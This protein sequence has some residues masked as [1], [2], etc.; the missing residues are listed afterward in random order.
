VTGISGQY[1]FV[2]KQDQ[3]AK[4][5]TVK[6]ARTIGDDAVIETGLQPGEQVV[7]DGQLQLED[8]TRLEINSGETKSA[9]P[10]ESTPANTGITP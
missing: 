7:T 5:R 3:T 6:V 1:V 10:I 8:G 2:V 4:M 9:L